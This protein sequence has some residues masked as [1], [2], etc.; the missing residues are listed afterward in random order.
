M[1]L[2]LIAIIYLTFISLGL[3]DA[4]LGAGWPVMVGELSVPLSYAGILSMIITGGTIVSS[5]LSDRMTHKFGTAAVTVVSVGLTAMALLGFSVADSFWILCLMALPYGLG[6]GA[7]DA[8]LNNYV[9][10]HYSSK[11]MSW[12]H[13]FWG[14][15]ATLGPYVMGFAIGAGHGWRMGYG[16]V[17][18]YQVGMTLFLVATLPVWKRAFRATGQSRENYQPLPLSGALKIRGVKSILV[19]FFGYSALEATA[20]LWASTYL[21][22]CR[23]IDPE[24]AA[25]FGAMFYMGLT[26]GRFFSGFIADRVGDKNMIRL[27]AGIMVLGLVLILLVSWLVLGGLVILG[28][29]AAP[30]YPSIIHATPHHFGAQNSQAI[31]GIQMAS[32]YTGSTL[33]P[34]LFGVIAQYIHVGCYPFFLTACLLIMLVMTEQVN[35]FCSCNY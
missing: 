25:F 32:A 23:G 2:F 17:G 3:P 22:T 29:G 27:G 5:L 9:A 12:L 10:V 18:L 20:G 34:P 8:A 33:M 21:V 11:Y 35:R 6:A 15:G 26:A 14:V 1:V 31:V 30:V 13:C 7:V 19:A 24:T 4:L 28:L 16:A